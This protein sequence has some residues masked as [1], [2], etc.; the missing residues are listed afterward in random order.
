MRGL[1]ISFGPYFYRPYFENFLLFCYFSKESPHHI[2]LI[3]GKIT[4]VNYIDNDLT[5]CHRGGTV[6]PG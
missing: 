2:G 4:L 3:Q 5:N 6:L 1:R